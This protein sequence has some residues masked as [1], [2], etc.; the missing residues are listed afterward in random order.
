M[1]YPCGDSGGEGQVVPDNMVVMHDG[2][3][4]AVGNYD[5]RLQPTRPFMVLEY[6]DAGDLRDLV[7]KRGGLSEALALAIMHQVAE[8]LCEAHRVHLVHRDIKPPNIFVASDGRAKLADFGIARSTDVNRPALT[9]QGAIVGSPM[10]MSPEQVLSDS[11]LDIR[12]DIYAL[13]AVL[14]F[15]LVCDPPYAGKLQEILHQHCTAPV[16]DVRSK[17]PNIGDKTQAIINRA[18]AK[19]RNN[20]YA[21]PSEMRDALLTRLGELGALPGG[22]V[23]ESTAKGDLSGGTAFR[24]G[25]L[26]HVDLL[27]LGHF[28]SCD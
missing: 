3:I 2:P 21:D 25:T 9:M 23:D 20:R 4:R 19:D 24:P 6:V 16:P 27:H 26:H 14:Y 18:M 1:Q 15:C 10:Y 17:R 5:L 13:G 12:S 22:H 11:T 7:E 28:H 8:G